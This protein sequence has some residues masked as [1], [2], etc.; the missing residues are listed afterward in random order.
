MKTNVWFGLGLVVLVGSGCATTRTLSV[1]PANRAEA[2][3]QAGVPLLQSTKKN[4]VTVW[5]VKPRYRVDPAELDAPEL[6]VVVRNRGT[7]AFDFSCADIAARSDDRPVSV[8][9]R[10]EFRVA[11]DR[12]AEARLDAVELRARVDKR[13]ANV[14]D[15]VPTAPLLVRGPNGQVSYDSTS[16]EAGSPADAKARIDD[17]AA[18]RRAEI[19]QW[20]AGRMAV[21]RTLLGRSRVK[22]GDTGGGLVALDPGALRGG[23]A[24]HVTVMA[25]G[26]AHEFVFDVGG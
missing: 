13:K 16:V 17:V 3:L 22:P 9:G 8:L 6:R 23:R 2:E 11:V 15:T 10:D 14:L 20:W 18:Q 25:A 7:Q 21:A 4:E 24:L 19:T 5:L 12:R 1:S 26:E